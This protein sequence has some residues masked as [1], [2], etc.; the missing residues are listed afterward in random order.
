MYLSLKA[1]HIIA[2]ILFLGNT[3]TGAFWKAHGD[4]SG[5]PRIM[6]H[7]IDGIIRSDRIF[8]VPGV[9]M[10]LVFGFG[11]AGIG[12]YP[13]LHTSWIWMSLIL[14]G[15]SGASYVRGVVPVQI[16]LRNLARDAAATGTFDK[17]EYARL[18]A[19]WNFWGIVAIVA[20]FGALALMVSKP[21]F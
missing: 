9:I 3:I 8:T 4:K 7:T 1:L 19:R 13:I 10:I 14:F 21:T 18:S 17:A 12:G 15:V 16:K 20:P 6:A 11:A 5:D 2:V